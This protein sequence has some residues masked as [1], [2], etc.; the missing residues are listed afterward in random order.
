MHAKIFLDTNILLYALSTQSMDKQRIAK[1]LMQDRITI[2]TQVINE[3]SVNLLKKLSFNETD[4][5]RFIESCY[6]RY[7]VADV[8]Q[9]VFLHA[10]HLRQNYMLSYFDSTIVATA[11]ENQCSILYSEDMQHNQVIDGSLTII[12]PF[13]SL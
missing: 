11:L 6:T 2:S 10:S 3:T 13:T 8:T 9:D 7:H 12:N 4:I 1:K 5:Q